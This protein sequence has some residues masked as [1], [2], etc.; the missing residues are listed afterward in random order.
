MH[1]TLVALRTRSLQLRASLMLAALVLLFCLPASTRGQQAEP[2]GFNPNVNGPVHAIAFQADGKILIGGEFTAVGSFSFKNL[3]RLNADGTVDATFFPNPNGTVRTIAVQSD[4]KILVGGDFTNISARAISYMAR[5]NPDATGDIFFG[6]Q[7]NGP[8]HSIVIQ[9][10][11]RILVGGAFTEIGG[12]SRNYAAR[13]F[14]SNGVADATFSPNANDTV[15]SIVIQPDGKILYG[16]TFTTLGGASCNGIGRVNST[17]TLDAAFNPNVSGGVT[18]I[19]LQPDGK[20]LIGGDFASVGGQVRNNMARLNTDGTLDGDFNPNA[21]GSVNAIAVLPDGA[22]LVGGNFSVIGGQAHAQLARLYSDGI[23]D[24]NFRPN[25]I[26]LSGVGVFAIVVQPGG[27]ILI[28][29]NFINI[30]GQLRNHMARLNAD[31]TLDGRIIPSLPLG[32]VFATAIQPDGMIL[33]GGTMRFLF[34]QR[35]DS[36]GRLYAGGELDSRVH[37]ID[38]GYVYTTA[39]QP[40]GKILA[41]GI[42]SSA[43]AIARNNIVRFNADGTIDSAFNP[44]TNDSILALALQPDGKI[45]VGGSF[46]SI[47]GQA[48]SYIARLNADGTPDTSFNP[49][50]NATVHTI[51]L[52]PDGKILIGG[53]FTSIGGQA[54]SYIARLNTDGTLDGSFDVNANSNVTC[55]VVQSDGNILVGGNFTSIGSLP[56]PRERIARLNPDGLAELFFNPSVDSRVDTIALQA[57]GKILIGGDFTFVSGVPRNFIARLLPNGTL[58]TGFDPNPNNN[59]RGIVLQGDGRI[60]VGGEFQSIGGR[61]CGLIARLLNNVAAQQ[62][63]TISRNAISWVLSGSTPQISRATF[64]LSTDGGSTYTLL[65]TTTQ[66]SSG[67]RYMLTGLNLPTNQQ[68]V[69]R[70]RGVYRGGSFSSSESILEY[71]GHSYLA[72]PT[73]LDFVQQPT[74]TTAGNNITPAVTVQLLDPSNNLINSNSDVTIS[75]GSNPGGGTLSGTTTVAAVGG[76][77]TF[78]NLAIDKLGTGYT[79]TASS[80]GL[81][82]ATSSPFNISAA[83]PAAINATSGT[84]QSVT[85]GQTFTNALQATVSDSFG[86]PVSG[87]AVTFTAPA[88]GASGTF[89]GNLGTITAS[90]N[91][92]GV[93]TATAFTANATAGSYNVIAS[94][95]SGSP[96]AAF[97]LTNTKINQAIT[98]TTHAPASAAYNSSFTVAAT[99]SSGLPVSYLSAGACTNSGATFT[100]TGSTGTCTVMYDQAGDG[101]YSDAA[102]VTESVTAQKADQTIS[103]DGLAARTFGDSDF[104]LSATASSGLTVAF[105]ASGECT[106]TGNT[107]HI[108]GAGSC[109]ITASQAGDSSYNPAQDV[110]RTFSVAKAVSTTTLTVGDAVYDGSPHGGTAGVTGIGGLNQSLSVTYAGRNATI[111]GPSPTPPTNAGDYTASATFSGDNDHIGSSASRDFTIAKATPTITWDKPSDITYGTALGGAQLNATASVAGNFVY[112]PGAGQVLHA[113]SHQMLHAEFT[114]AD[115]A[116]YNSVT[117]DVAINVLRR[118]LTVTA[119]NK[120]RPFGAANPTF[121]YTITGFTGSDT[122][123]GSVTGEP[124]ITTAADG[125]SIVGNYSITVSA[126]TLSSTDYDFSFVNGTLMVTKTDQYITFGPL[127][128]K[129]YGE[130]DFNVTATATSNLAVSFSAAGNCTVTGNL[131]HISGAGS[132]TI[133]ALQAGNSNFNAAPDV[134]Q[135]FTIDKAN[136]TITFNALAD[137]NFGDSDF[138]LSVTASSGLSVNLATSGQC[139]ISGS[140]VHLMGAGSCQITASQSG[141]SNFNRAPDVQRAFNIAKAVTTTD[142]TSAV[143]PS[144]SG[145]SAA[146]TATVTSQAGMPT[147]TVTFK[148]G[149]NAIAGCSNVA[150]TSE[151]ATCSTSALAP[152]AHLITADYSG[153]MNFSVSTGTLPGGQ[154]VNVNSLIS[155]DDISLTEGDSGTKS[156]DFTVTLSQA[157]NLTVKVDYATAQGTATAGTD[158]QQTSG[159]L[160]FNAG[161]TAKSISVLVNGDTVNEPDEAFTLNLSNPVN[162]TVSDNQGS[163][164]ILNDDAPGVQF[165]SANYRIN[166]GLNN[167]P[168]G[169]TALSVEVVRTGDISQPATVKYFTSDNSGG[170]ECDQVTGFA[171]QRCDYTMVGATLRFA[172]N[173]ATKNFIIPITNDG[174]KEGTEVFTLQLQNP[175]G[176]SLGLI[177]QATVSI[178]DDA[179]DATPTTPQQNPY[180]SNEFFVRQD[181]LDNLGR[182]TDQAGF[183]DWTNVLNKCGPQKGFIGSP[184]SCD[185][186]HVAHGFF[187]SEEFTTSGFLLFRLYA[188]GRGRMPLYREFI[189]DM[190][191]LSGFGISDSVKQQNLADYLQQFSNDT[192]FVSRFQAV[193]QASQ[194]AQLIAMLEQAAN[195]TL[196]AT[197]TTLPGQPQQYGRAELIQKRATGQFSLI[198]TIKA[199]VEQK[200]VYDRYFMEGEVTIMYFVYLRRDPSLNDPNLVGWTQWVNVFT[201]GGVRDDGVV[202]QPRDIHHLIFGFIYSTEYRK[203]FGQP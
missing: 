84:P 50:A 42:F 40:D 114:P 48:R 31:G 147:G 129:T 73:R 145:Q 71:F 113:G 100:L 109:I 154:E 197:T 17:G 27:K 196:P 112:T 108:T 123:A 188:V 132:C 26:M 32:S 200:V 119:E 51:A 174:Y 20:I 65:G 125:S 116:N 176:A 151:K 121:T 92:S 67:N 60:I 173:E 117:K 43:N 49:N 163:G 191:T 28:G 34:G 10:N 88:L 153:D 41:G 157:S 75:L 135:N 12:I 178:E 18:T 193:S 107:V 9:P 76:T 4:G 115:M 149:G 143:N 68:L 181:Y 158:Y 81:T 2:D 14:Q 91:S 59:I 46:T 167:T 166:E 7:P 93:A 103:F 3:A 33:I 140:S 142:V 185:R 63:L 23:G 38:A 162:A 30:D 134:R 105:N 47:G 156:F 182:D 69:I 16:G 133:T 175:V 58:D 124:F 70:A 131:V 97:S 22:I 165:S 72:A 96:A 39:V 160:T 152:G 186:A 164:T 111:Y 80:S 66:F 90:T 95:G 137:K 64:E 146:F 203:R 189:P 104:T 56:L 122:Q 172:A 78:Y 89:A 24:L 190:A 102:R 53:I 130:A 77:A 36:F 136:Q 194:A 198:E 82:E 199:F 85:L 201:N 106:V 126:G 148:D 5:L 83:S 79:L 202:I 128:N 44:G 74:N 195:V 52:Q 15:Y 98:V 57:D 6:P 62:S 37:P 21:N 180:L 179:A 8:V 184:F 150:L 11:G 99:S 139:I 101:T 54:R 19:A 192:E 187:G 170:L 141:N 87:V 61:D 45:L 183:T 168:Q 138:T 161:E 35:D 144:T 127:P 13:L 159:T 1:P 177:N 171:S 55:I 86:N 120:S 94:I 29:G 155:I 118:T 169:F 25:I 110:A